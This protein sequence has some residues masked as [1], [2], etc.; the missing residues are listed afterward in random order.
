M[1]KV[2]FEAKNITK[3][4]VKYADTDKM[5]VVNNGRYLEYFEAGRTELMREYGLPYTEFE[6]AGFLLPVV[7]AF[8]SFKSPANYDDILEVEASLKFSYEPFLRFEYNIFRGNTTIAIGYTIH[9]FLNSE[10]RR[11][12]KPPK[13]FLDALAKAGK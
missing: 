3:I 13:V 6:K 10:T 2:V 8:A 1:P 12:V 4:R 11:P 7:E 9:S 5:G